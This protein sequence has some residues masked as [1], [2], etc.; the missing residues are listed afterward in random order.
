MVSG[1]VSERSHHFGILCHLHIISKYF[2]M[3]CYL[4]QEASFASISFEVK[5]NDNWTDNVQSFEL[6]F[7]I[8]VA[9]RTR[10]ELTR[11]KNK[12][13]GK[14]EGKSVPRWNPL[15]IAGSLAKRKKPIKISHK[16][17]YLIRSH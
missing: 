11:L 3:A 10:S 17:R 5:S 4:K 2:D 6:S 7:D 14:W 13:T 8:L 1:S 12:W 9:R 16:A 15:S